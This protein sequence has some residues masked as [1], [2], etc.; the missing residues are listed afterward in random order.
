MNKII[1]GKQ[2][3]ILWDVDDLKIS[4]VDAAVVTSIIDTLSQEFGKHADLTV[5]WGDVHDYLGMILYYSKRGKIQFQMFNYIGNM[6]EEL[7]EWWL[8]GPAATP[9]ANHLFEVNDDAEKLPEKEALLYHHHTAKLLYLSKRARPDIQT[10]V[11]FMCTIV[12]QPD[13]DDL[14]KLQ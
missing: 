8:D 2:C 7:P 9:A 14:K 10:S 6:I 5:N 1:N 12:T 3:T 13:V 11:A 4:H